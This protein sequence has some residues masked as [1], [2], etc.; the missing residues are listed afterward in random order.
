MTSTPQPT[1][2]ELAL[3]A[4]KRASVQQ[5]VEGMM[6]IRHCLDQLDHQQIW[7]R[8]H[9]SMNSI[10]NLLLHLTGNMRQWLIAGLTDG[11][12]TR[13]RQLEFDDRSLRSSHELLAA[14]EH[15]ADTACDCIQQASL[16]DLMQRRRVQQFDLD[17]FQT[18]QDSVC[19]FRGHVQEIIHMTRCLKSDDYRFYFIPQETSS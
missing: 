12:D 9:A 18:I 16:H 19:H 2:S 13:Y 1:D 10:A 3:S 6:K 7:W 15:T 8:P 5:I 17:G 11:Q 4:Y 14:L